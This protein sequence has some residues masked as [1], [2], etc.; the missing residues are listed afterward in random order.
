[1]RL[2][3]AGG[4]LNWRCRCLA[5]PQHAPPPLAHRLTSLRAHVCWQGDFT[6]ARVRAR[7]RGALRGGRA[8]VVLSDMAPSF[9]GDRQRDHLTAMVLCEEV[10][11][12]AR[13]CAAACAR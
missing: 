7:L 10:G 9:S 4:R 3:L 2:G 5:T 13:V 6:D 1:L 8:D 12:R 11:V